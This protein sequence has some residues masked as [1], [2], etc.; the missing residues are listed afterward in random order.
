[1]GKLTI[2]IVC[3]GDDELAPFLKQ[4][5]DC[6]IS[7]KAMLKFYKGK[8]EGTEVVALFSG[9]CK[10]NAAIATQI[11]ID[12][13]QCNVIINS[14]T[15]GAVGKSLEIFS[16]VVST[17]LAYHDVDKEILT[18][19]HP[20]LS[21]IWIKAD[22]QLVSLARNTAN[23]YTPDYKVIFGRMVTGEKFISDKEKQ[24]IIDVFNPFSVDMESMSIAHVC[25]ANRIPFISVRTITDSADEEA[26]E[27]FDL[28]C[29]KASFQSADFVR[30]MLKEW[31]ECGLR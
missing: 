25:Y 26:S 19:F 14:G 17:E 22:E 5:K 8:I 24:F 18:D 29:S 20:W 9:V 30:L 23:K 10:V 31:K 7:H 27:L 12:T 21:S 16:T 2:G 3:A 1:M 13:Y 11:L 28:N 15:A 4:I 6:Q